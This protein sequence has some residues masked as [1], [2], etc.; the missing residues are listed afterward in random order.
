MTPTKPWVAALESEFALDVTAEEVF[1]AL[2]FRYV[3]HHY[4]CHILEFYRFAVLNKY[5][6]FTKAL[7]WVRDVA[8]EVMR[9]CQ[10][11]CNSFRTIQCPSS[12]TAVECLG[13]RSVLVYRSFLAH[14]FVSIREIRG[15]YCHI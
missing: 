14:K 3:Y 12:A 1:A 2:L 13:G 11:R 4:F 7:P 15:R 8:A 10:C 6:D 5:A 9:R